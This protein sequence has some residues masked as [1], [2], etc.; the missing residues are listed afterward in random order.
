MK[1]RA[2]STGRRTD[3]NKRMKILVAVDLSEYSQETLE[4][5]ANLGNNMEAELIVAN[6]INKRDVENFKKLAVDISDMAVAEFLQHRKNDRFREIQGLIEKSSCDHI[7]IKPVVSTGVPFKELIAIATNEK[8][9][10]VVMGAKGRT[11]LSEVLFGST[12]DKMFRHCPVPLLSI[13]FMERGKKGR[14][15]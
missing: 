2:M 5:A 15:A 12:A 11:N 6:V 10:L 9:D 7:Q 8:V 13:R 1:H 14:S 3:M 4:Y